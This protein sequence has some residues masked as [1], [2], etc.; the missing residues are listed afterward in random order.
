LA[1]AQVITKVSRHEAHLARNF[2]IPFF[3]IQNEVKLC[4]IS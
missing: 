1:A 3:V 2:P 4:L